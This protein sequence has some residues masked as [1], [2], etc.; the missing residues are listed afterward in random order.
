M[1]GENDQP[2]LNAIMEFITTAGVETPGPAEF[3]REFTEARDIS[4]EEIKDALTSSVQRSRTDRRIQEAVLREDWER[5]EALALSEFRDFFRHP[6]EWLS[7][8]IQDDAQNHPDLLPITKWPGKIPL[9]QLTTT[10][11]VLIALVLIAAVYPFLPPD[12]Q[13]DIQGES[14]IVAAAAA[15]LAVIKR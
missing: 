12:V 4:L 9:G 11:L 7:R 5:R 15:V 6:P 10:Q 13:A 3:A 1:S 14:A 8:Y 2:D